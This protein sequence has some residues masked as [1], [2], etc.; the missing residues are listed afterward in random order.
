MTSCTDSLTV[1]SYT[2][3]HA[4]TAMEPSE[5]DVKDLVIYDRE[6]QVR[7]HDKLEWKGVLGVD[8]NFF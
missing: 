5:L 3:R 7:R 6:S 8:G 1:A 4:A 2:Q